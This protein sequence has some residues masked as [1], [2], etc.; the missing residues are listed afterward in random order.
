LNRDVSQDGLFA[1]EQWSL[2]AAQG[3]IQDTSPPAS[4]DPLRLVDPHD[5]AQGLDDRARSYLHVN[6]SMC[7]Q[8]GGNAIVSFYL[9]RD[10]PLD[11][12]NTNKGT[13]IGTFG[14]REARIIAPGDPYR[15]LLLYRM[16]KLGYARMPYIGSRVVDGRGVALVAEWIRSL[17]GGTAG[18]ASA[19]LASDSAEAKALRLLSSKNSSPQATRQSAIQELLKSTEGALSLI[20]AM[21]G[22]SLAADDVQA[23][24]ALGNAVPSSDVRGLLETFLP[25]G[26]RRTTLGASINPQ[27]ILSRRGDHQ[28]GKLIFFSDGARCRSCHEIDDR[29]RSLGPTL[30]EIVKKYPSPS[31]LL[32]HILEPSKIGSLAAAAGDDRWAN[33]QRSAGGTKRAGGGY[34][35][36]GETGGANR[37]EQRPANA[38][39]REVADAGSNPERP[40]GARGRR[41][42]RIP[43]IPQYGKVRA[44]IPR[45]CRQ[46][47]L[48]V[49]IR[50]LNAHDQ[51]ALVVRRST[52]H[53]R[54]QLD[55]IQ[56]RPSEV[57]TRLPAHHCNT[58]GNAGL[59]SVLRP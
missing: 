45:P 30:L 7:H 28:R 49:V 55:A 29:S 47:S 19:P 53:H 43:A 15:S 14:M 38:E 4:D 37:P 23:A 17:P 56:I 5:E 16:S 42:A 36:P 8:P 32:E 51:P 12:L 10:L 26:K 40:D 11:Q 25:E 22:R 54:R 59:K 41:P 48:P 21:H 39:E 20:A 24:A 33:H 35:D 27:A 57:P 13:G 6:C 2:L 34:Q 50:R 3:V 46:I 9:R 1:A 52:G 31:E 58:S 18:I 44:D